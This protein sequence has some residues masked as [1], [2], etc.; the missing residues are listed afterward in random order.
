MGNEA[1]SRGCRL[2]CKHTT[3]N[4]GVYMHDR[5]QRFST[6]NESNIGK[7]RIFIAFMAV[8]VFLALPQSSRAGDGANALIGIAQMYNRMDSDAQ[9]RYQRSLESLPAGGAAPTMKRYRDQGRE[10]DLRNNGRR[11][12]VNPYTYQNPYNNI[13][14]G[15]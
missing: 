10:N 14:R 7:I 13:Y 11:Q 15:Q 8:V 12:H 6:K 1:V 4:K 2:D 5:G 9:E 3:N